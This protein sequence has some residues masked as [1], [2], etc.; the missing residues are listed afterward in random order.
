MSESREELYRLWQNAEQRE[1]QARLALARIADR[2]RRIADGKIKT[3]AVG[4]A[5]YD[6]SVAQAILDD[7][8]E[9]EA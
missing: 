6:L 3:T 8:K 9:Q 5:E 7:R 4:A 2:A 1:H